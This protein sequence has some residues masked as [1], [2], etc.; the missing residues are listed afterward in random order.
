MA[1]PDMKNIVDEIRTLGN[2]ID[3]LEKIIQTKLIA[4]VVPDEYE[5]KAIEEFEKK[6]KAG[7]LEFSSLT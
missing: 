3:R 2:K 5:K 7:K 4:E 1:Q 6:K